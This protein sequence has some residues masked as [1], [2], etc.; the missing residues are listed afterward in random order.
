MECV[1]VLMVYGENRGVNVVKHEE[2]WQGQHK[3]KDH[4]SFLLYTNVLHRV[5]TNSHGKTRFAIIS[6]NK[7]YK[8]S[9][10]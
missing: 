10:L 8:K 1:H 2:P 5:G 7:Y 9:F 6:Y 3:P 4:C